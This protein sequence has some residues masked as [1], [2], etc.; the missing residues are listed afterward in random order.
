VSTTATGQTI[1]GGATVN[2]SANGNLG[3]GG[4]ITVNCGLSPLQYINVNAAMQISPP[5]ADSS[6]IVMLTMVTGAGAVTF[7]G[8]W[9]VGTNTGDTPIVS[10]VSNQYSIFVW[11]ING[12]P[13][14][15]VASHQP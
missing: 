8:G 2:T 15:R 14:Y 4:N 11:R 3:S 5:A 10:T 1:S 9:K 12:V 7:V 13:G 6:C